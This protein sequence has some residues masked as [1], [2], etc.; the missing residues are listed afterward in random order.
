MRH[1]VR[2]ATLV[3]RPA[4]QPQEILLVKHRSRSSGRVIWLSPGGGLE[5]EDS[6]IFDC[7]RREA[8]EESGLDVAVSRIAYIHEFRDE[9]KQI[10]H[11]AFYMVADSISG[12]V[13]LDYLPP[14]ATDALSILE[15]LWVHQSDV[16]QLTVYP[17]YIKT[18]DFWR[19]AAEGFSQTRYLGR[20]TEL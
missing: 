10:Q 11:V 7:A 16:A 15:A 1:R 17:E 20:M 5:P 9:V 3:L 8:K 19:D 2:A 14:D 4:E 13:S 12:E 6:S 18:A